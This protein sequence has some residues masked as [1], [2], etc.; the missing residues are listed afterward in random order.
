MAER[1]GFHSAMAAGVMWLDPVAV[2]SVVA[3]ATQA[4]TVGSHVLVLPYRNPI[5][6]ANEIAALDL[7]SQRR[8]LLGVGTGWMDEEFGALAVP[9][10]ERGART[11]EYIELMR[12]LWRA[13]GP[14]SFQGKYFQ[15]DEMQLGTKPETP[16]GPP[17]WVGGN[18]P[19]ALKRAGRLGDGW[20]GFE[21]FLDQVSG[22][23]SRIHNA[24]RDAGRDPDSIRLSVRRG[25]VPPFEVVDF[26]PDRRSVSGDAAVV[27][28]EL[29]G[30]ADAGVTL[31]VFDVAMPPS[32]MIKTMEWFASE[33][34]PLLR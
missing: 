26:L 17:V 18:S 23:A 29:N 25:L 2:M 16:G 13:D 8:V 5:V 11:D 6:L 27:A 32:D 19:A 7:L 28:A 30:Y 33:V 15:F 21:V 1:L 3:G 9:R 20:L 4:I 24:A 31:M 34:V 10:S 22:S 12:A 14:I